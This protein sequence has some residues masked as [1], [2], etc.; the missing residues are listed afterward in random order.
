MSDATVPD[1]YVM[2][3]DWRGTCVWSSR[4]DG[5]ATPGAFVWSQFAAD[6]QEDASHAL[7]RVVA[8]RERAELEVVHQQGDR[9][10]TWLWPLD[11]P[12]AAV[13]ALAKRIPK[14]IESLTARERECLGMVA[15]GMDTREVSESLDVSM[16]TVHTHMKRS[17][18][19]LGL[20]NFESLISFAARYF[21]PANIPFG[22]A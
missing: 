22:P 5:P 1:I 20:P 3:C 8:L 14:E 7:G 17:R 15:Q 10:R 2:L 4:E 16:S 9:F 12:E 11:S 6:S 21:Y 18:E 13:C 19:K